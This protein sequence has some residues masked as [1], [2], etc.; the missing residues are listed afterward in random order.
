MR[1]RNKGFIS[2][3]LEYMASGRQVIIPDDLPVFG[4]FIGWFEAH[5]ISYVAAEIT[6][7]FT[8]KREEGQ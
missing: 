1:G 2:V 8:I 4:P 6:M 3:V 7:N 5:W